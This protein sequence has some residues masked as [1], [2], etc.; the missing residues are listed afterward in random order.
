MVFALNVPQAIARALIVPIRSNS[1][2]SY[3]REKGSGSTSH[4]SKVESINDR[5][6]IITESSFTRHRVEQSI[7]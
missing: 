7:Y 4:F 2:Y 3:G 6:E 5:V 1:S